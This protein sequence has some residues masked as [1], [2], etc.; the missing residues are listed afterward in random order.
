[1]VMTIRRG[2]V[3]AC[4]LLT[5]GG[6]R[7]HA[8]LTAYDSFSDTPVGIP[9]IGTSNSGTGFVDPW[10]PGGFNAS[11]FAN[12]TIASGSLADDGLLTAGNSI[13]TAAQQAISGLSRDL[14]VPLGAAGTTAYLSVLL[15]PEGVLDAGVLGGY[16]GLY[17]NAST[18][19][20][21]LSQDLFLGKPG[22]SDVYDLE[23]RGGTNRQF[24]NTTAG[25]GRTVLLV[26]RADFTSGIDKFTLYVNATP[27]GPEPSS[28]T[29]KQDSNV[30][31][32]SSLTLYS[33]GAYSVDEI[34]IG[35]TFADV[36]PAAVPEPSSIVLVA[37]GGL[38]VLGAMRPRRGT[39][40]SPG[41][42][43]ES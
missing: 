2:L 5:M 19:T 32:I 36:V 17:L 24:T 25:V 21:T 13:T 20:P 33:T 12:Y 18:T 30:G 39:E 26:L 37:L 8:G 43:A 14:S 38:G 16:F 40:S 41:T 23:D 3:F 34:R 28:G 29:V 31:T 22:I 10:H 1:M 6:S 7:A 15:R 4:A 27:G 9:L 35:T 42:R 11:L